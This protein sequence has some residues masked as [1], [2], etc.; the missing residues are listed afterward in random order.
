MDIFCGEQGGG[1]KE[2]KSKIGNKNRESHQREGGKAVKGGEYVGGGKSLVRDKRNITHRTF[3]KE[4][5]TSNS[6]GDNA[7]RNRRQIE[8]IHHVV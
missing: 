7:S 8:L 6:K 2:Q 5:A 4:T 3:D 1:V